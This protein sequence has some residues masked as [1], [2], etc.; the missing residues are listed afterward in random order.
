MMKLIVNDAYNWK[1]IPEF[2]STVEIEEMDRVNRRAW[3]SAPEFARRG[4]PGV[5]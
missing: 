1:R 3:K 4:S 2:N 5:T